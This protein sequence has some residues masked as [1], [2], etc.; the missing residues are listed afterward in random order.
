MTNIILNILRDSRTDMLW[1][2]DCDRF[3]TIDSFNGPLDFSK[4]ENLKANLVSAV[5]YRIGLSPDIIIAKDDDGNFAILTL[6]FETMGNGG[7]Y[8]SFSDGFSYKSMKAYLKESELERIVY[9]IVEDV[10]NGWQFLELKRNYNSNPFISVR[11][12][13]NYTLDYDLFCSKVK[14]YIDIE[15][16]DIDNEN[17]DFYQGDLTSVPERFYYWW[18]VNNPIGVLSE[19]LKDK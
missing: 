18:V 17:S 12:V 3:F 2:Y 8:V 11:S 4:M 9:L 5:N 14:E 6:Y 10:R 1:L 16:I 15:N 7:V 13:F 19:D